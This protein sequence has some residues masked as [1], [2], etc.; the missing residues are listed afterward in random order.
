MKGVHNLH[1][2]YPLRRIIIQWDDS[3][4]G[5]TLAA[6]HFHP[7]ASFTA[8]FLCSGCDSPGGV[9][10]CTLK[11]LNLKIILLSFSDSLT[12]K[13]AH[14]QVTPALSASFILLKLL[15]I[16]NSNNFPR[17]PLV[18]PVNHPSPTTVL[19]CNDA[20]NVFDQVELARVSYVEQCKGRQCHRGS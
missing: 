11:K 17:C 6:V 4:L 3:L 14:S 7:L 9:Y 15:I 13:R 18:E 19:Y 10:C 2:E 16:A 20:W 12:C 1:R 5:G 8:N